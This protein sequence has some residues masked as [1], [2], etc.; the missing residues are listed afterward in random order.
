MSDRKKCIRCERTIDAYASICPYCN[1]NQSM[2]APVREAVPVEV[3]EYKPPE[4]RNAKKK[5]IYAGIGVLVLILA[6]FGGMIINRD[7]TPKNVPQT[8]D[9]T[10]ENTPVS[11]PKRADTQLVPTNEPGGIE[12]PITSAPVSGPVP[13][14]PANEWDRS[15]ATA[16]SSAEYA[17][18]AQ[19]AAAEKKKAQP[20]VDPRSL[21]GAAY[22]QQP[23]RRPIA[24]RVAVAAA[25]T[26]PVPEYQGLPSMRAQGSAVLDLTVG[27]NGRV[28]GINVRRAPFGG[29]GALIGAVQHWRFRPATVNGQP[30]AAPYSVQ[31]QFKG[32]E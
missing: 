15:D 5:L 1:W 9:E 17:Q 2:A 30:V 20:L 4:E 11:A 23:Q 13:G 29:T 26:R 14:T 24:N 19:R 28:T 10:S 18:L 12:Q 25:R 32:H 22:A 3:A 8:I 16:V 7:G 31:I 21:T 27:P 6:F